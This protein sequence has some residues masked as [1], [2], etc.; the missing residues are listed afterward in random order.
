MSTKNGQRIYRKLDN[1][2]ERQTDRG[3]EQRSRFRCEEV[4]ELTRK[5]QMDQ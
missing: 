2:L 3:R 5:G 4:K 1:E